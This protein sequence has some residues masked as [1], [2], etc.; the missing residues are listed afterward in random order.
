MAPLGRND[1]G[2]CGEGVVADALFTPEGPRPGMVDRHR[3]ARR[4]SST[5][6]ASDGAARR[7][8]PSQREVDAAYPLP[9]GDITLPPLLAVGSA[10][11]AMMTRLTDS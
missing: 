11:L 5:T 7:V 3:P 1:L 8:L 2:H 4:P 9:I 6:L 10:Y